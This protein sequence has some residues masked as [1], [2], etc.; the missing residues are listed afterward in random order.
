MEW[1]LLV[2]MFLGFDVEPVDFATEAECMAVA[3]LF[4]E[5]DPTIEWIDVSGAV[6]GWIQPVIRNTIEC[7]GPEDRLEQEAPPPPRPEPA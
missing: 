5:A 4:A 1:V 6:A 3:A 7:E 2:S